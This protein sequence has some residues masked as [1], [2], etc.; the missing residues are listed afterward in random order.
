MLS[1]PVPAGWHEEQ[2]REVGTSGPL[3]H[4][5]PMATSKGKQ[6]VTWYSEE[7]RVE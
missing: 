7:G 6:L 5:H 2:R 4:C 1:V 3:R